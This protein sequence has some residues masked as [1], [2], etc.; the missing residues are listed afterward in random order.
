[1]AVAPSRSS[2]RFLVRGLGRVGIDPGADPDDQDGDVVQAA[3]EVGQVDQ[4]AAG[5]AR[6]EIARRRRRAPGR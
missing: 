4:V 3:A 2:E 5:V 6:V 1:M